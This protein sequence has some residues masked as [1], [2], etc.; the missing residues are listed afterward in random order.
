[1]TVLW[2]L[3]ALVVAALTA[4][5]LYGAVLALR[6]DPGFDGVLRLVVEAVAGG[7]VVAYCVG[8]ARGTRPAPVVDDDRSGGAGDR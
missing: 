4:V 1:M 7:V 2:W 6:A 3:A 5:A 8:K